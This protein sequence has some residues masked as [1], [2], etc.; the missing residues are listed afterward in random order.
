MKMNSI[1]K[2]VLY[3]E[4]EKGLKIFYKIDVYLQKFP[5][6]EEEPEE[7]EEPETPEEEL[8]T[9]EEKTKEKMITEAIHQFKSD[10]VINVP[11][12]DVENIQSLQDLLDYVSD[13][14]DRGNPVLDEVATEIV[15][16][17]ADVG[18]KPIEDVVD[19]G[20]KVIVDIDYGKER[21]DSVGFKVLKNAGTNAISIVMKKDNQVIP[22]E[23]QLPVFNQQLVILRNSIV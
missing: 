20:D 15:L 23:F 5:E 18:T 14:Q 11:I 6:K 17:L 7:K 2:E 4:K 1:L 10:G 9:E 13:K 22:S 3:E 16:A 8:P 19:K 12:E 21:D